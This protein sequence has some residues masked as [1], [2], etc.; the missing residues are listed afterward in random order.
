MGKT[1]ADVDQEKPAIFSAASTLIAATLEDRL[2]W[3]F[4]SDLPDF[5]TSQQDFYGDESLD[6]DKDT[7]LNEIFEHFKQHETN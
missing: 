6:F 7:M 1:N 5:F 3:Q 4:I 2:R